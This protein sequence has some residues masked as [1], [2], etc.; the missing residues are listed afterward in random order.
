MP[1]AG[2]MYFVAFFEILMERFNTPISSPKVSVY[3]PLVCMGY[4]F[5]RSVQAIS[6][7]SIRI[8][9][10]EACPVMSFRLRF[11]NCRLIGK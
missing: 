4:P 8:S 1:D 7:V 5:S 3:L 2:D 6:S 9:S 10:R 11:V